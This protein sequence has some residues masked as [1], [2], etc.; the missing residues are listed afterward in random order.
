MSKARHAQ[1]L[2]GAFETSL[3]ANTLAGA[4][5]GTPPCKG[6]TFFSLRQVGFRRQAPDHAAWSARH[7]ERS[8]AMDA[9]SP[10]E[11]YAEDWSMHPGATLRKK[12]GLTAKEQQALALHPAILDQA[13]FE[14][15]ELRGKAFYTDSKSLIFCGEVR[16]VLGWLRAAGVFV[17]CIVT[18]PPFYGQRDY[19]VENQIGLELSP[20]DYIRKLADAFDGAREVLSSTGSLWVNIGDTYWNG[21]GEHKGRDRKQTARRFGL[22][23]QDRPGDGKLCK[24]KQLLLIPHRLAIALQDRDWIVRNDNIWVKPNPIPDQVRDR[25]S[26]SHE[27]VFHFVTQRFYFYD[28]SKVGRLTANGTFMPPTDTWEVPLSKGEKLHKATFSEE[29]VR[30]PI[31]ATTPPCGVVLDPFAGSGTSLVFARRHGYRSI[32]ID[33]KEEYCQIMKDSICELFSKD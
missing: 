19:E 25:S 4:V 7:D 33:I 16:E 9:M 15:P 24:N 21:R 3:K 28:R 29:L 2:K 8:N 5:F 11:S 22:R 6:V 12:R 14:S 1:H 10:K 32:G 27:Y 18:S 26:V 20:E 17:D 30:I 31:L 23:P 13:I